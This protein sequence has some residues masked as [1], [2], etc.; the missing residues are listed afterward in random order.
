MQRILVIED[1]ADLRLLMAEALRLDRFEV[2]HLAD[3]GEARRWLERRAFDLVI[4]DL[5]EGGH[6]DTLA[7]L[8]AGRHGVPLLI[9]TGC[10]KAAAL[11][12][13]EL[14]AAQI[15]MKPFALDVLLDAARTHVRSPGRASVA[16]THGGGAVA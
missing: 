1:D 9:C 2:V 12:P 14:G 11:D 16:S 7:G 13:A 15:I 5:P 4:T 6:L 3:F 10:P 8:D